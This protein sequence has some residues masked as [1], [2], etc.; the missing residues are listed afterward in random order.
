MFARMKVSTKLLGSF[1]ITLVLMGGLAVY[2]IIQ[3]SRVNGSTV[4]LTTVRMPAVRTILAM[5]SDVNRHRTLEFRLLMADNDPAEEATA[6][7]LL[8]EKMADIKK[9]QAEYAK[10]ISSPEE[11]QIYDS[12]ERALDTYR[13]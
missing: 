7:Q 2:S 4:E 11:Q 6:T 3:M 10:L 9:D 1:A 5:K 13:Q 8:D 12:Y